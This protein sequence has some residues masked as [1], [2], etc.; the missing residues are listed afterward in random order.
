MCPSIARRVRLSRRRRALVG[1]WQTLGYRMVVIGLFAGM[2]M[3]AGATGLP[4]MVMSLGVG[5]ALIAPLGLMA[6][7]AH[8]RRFRLASVLGMVGVLLDLVL[9]VLMLY[10]PWDGYPPLAQLM[11][12][13]TAYAA[14]SVLA[15]AAVTSFGVVRALWGAGDGPCHLGQ[16]TPTT[17]AFV[18]ES[19][20]ASELGEGAR[21][22]RRMVGLL[23]TTC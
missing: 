17:E 16:S 13:A 9:V 11:R 18:A 12:V 8:M 19:L 6:V 22:Q 5:A 2:L 10:G 21:R 14:A 4:V 3:A 7:S 23:P 20:V 15:G 1:Q